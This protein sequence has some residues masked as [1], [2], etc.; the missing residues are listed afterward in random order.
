VDP[1]LS[2]HLV[3]EKHMC[4]NARCLSTN[5]DMTAAIPNYFYESKVNNGNN[6]QCTAYDSVCQWLITCFHFRP[7]LNL[8]AILNHS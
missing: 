1:C 7:Q 6:I 3:V 2:E 4:R 8:L 5:L